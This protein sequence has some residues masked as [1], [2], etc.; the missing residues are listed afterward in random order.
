MWHYGLQPASLLCPWRSPG[1]NTGVCCHALLQQIF[2]TQGLNL[3]LLRLLHWRVGSLPLVPPGKPKFVNESKA[4]QCLIHLGCILLFCPISCSSVFCWWGH[5]FMYS[6]ILQIMINSLLWAQ[7]LAKSL[8]K[9]QHCPLVLGRR[10][11]S[12]SFYVWSPS[13]H[14]VHTQICSFFLLSMKEGQND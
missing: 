1:K 14:A 12:H 2:L 5:L 3:W 11:V 10:K 13:F 4:L 9:R 8:N 6:F 7:E